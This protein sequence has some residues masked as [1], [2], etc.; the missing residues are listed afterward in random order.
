MLLRAVGE[1]N[2]LWGP[3][4]GLTF[5]PPLDLLV[6]LV[7]K[8]GLEVEVDF[9]L[10]LA[11]AFAIELLKDD[12]IVRFVAPRLLPWHHAVGAP[13]DGLHSHVHSKACAGFVLVGKT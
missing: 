3:V 4:V 5:L 1:P 12:V 6:A 11:D 9:T 8:H 10:P 13:V 2:D 7:I